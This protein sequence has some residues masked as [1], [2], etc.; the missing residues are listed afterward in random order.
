M[1]AA[2][3]T[4]PCFPPEIQKLP[5]LIFTAMVFHTKIREVNS[6]KKIFLPFVEE[7]LDLES[8]SIN[9]EV[10][11]KNETIY[12]I[13]TLIFWGFTANYPCRICKI[14]IKDFLKES[15]FIKYRN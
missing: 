5:E 13:L 8:K 7:L 14:N 12:F 9:N 1:G 15:K 2:Y 4:L 10:E 6:T 3:Y 11:G